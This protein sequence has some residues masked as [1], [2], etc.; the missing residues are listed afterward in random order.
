[1]NNIYLVSGLGADGRVFNYLTFPEKCNIV[2][3]KMGNQQ[4]AKLAQ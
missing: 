1:M 2:H 4:S 3:I